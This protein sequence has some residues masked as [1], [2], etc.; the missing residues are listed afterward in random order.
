MNLTEIQEG[1]ENLLIT[2]LRR[3]KKISQTHIEKLT[4]KNDIADTNIKIANSLNK[5]YS[6]VAKDLTDK[7]HVTRNALGHD[8]EHHKESPEENPQTL[9]T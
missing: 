9:F 7:L 3:N 4:Y 1:Y 5:Y 6:E 2:Y 8:D